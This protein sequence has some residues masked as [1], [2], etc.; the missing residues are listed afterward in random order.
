LLFQIKEIAINMAAAITP[1]T[2]IAISPRLTIDI[3]K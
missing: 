2:A 3:S 1:P